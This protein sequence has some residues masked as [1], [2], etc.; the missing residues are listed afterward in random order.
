MRER[1]RTEREL[2]TEDLVDELAHLSQSW[3]DGLP[4]H[5][6]ATSG[7]MDEAVSLEYREVLGYVG[8][9]HVEQAR[10]LAGRLRCVAQ[11]VHE[12]VTSR[13]GER[14]E[15]GGVDGVALSLLGHDPSIAEFRN[16]ATWQS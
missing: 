9:A 5:A 11:V 16:C 15:H 10:Q 2:R 1:V 13:V 4:Q 12:L 8:T 14:R 6:P 3:I 7:S